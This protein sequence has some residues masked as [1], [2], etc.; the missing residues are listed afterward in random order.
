[1]LWGLRKGWLGLRNGWVYWMSR[2]HRRNIQKA[3]SVLTK[4]R[5]FEHDGQVIAYLKKIDPYVFEEMVVQIFQQ[6]GYLIWLT[7]SYSGDGGID[8]KVY[9]PT[10]GWCLIQSKRY[11][12]A[13]RTQ[14][15]HDFIGVVG[16][17]HG[18]FVHSGTS[19]DDIRAQLRGSRV[20]M[21]SG[22]YLVR[23]IRKPQVLLKL[24]S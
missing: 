18:C 12:K 5:S 6:A 7:P 24:F 1:M 11:G 2:R 4:V 22:S 14:H 16:K 20:R 8:G 23:A 13:I 21:L 17:K 9:H 15:V 3:R 19:T 10:L